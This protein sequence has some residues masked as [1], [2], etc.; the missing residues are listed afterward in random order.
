MS[1]MRTKSKVEGV[2]LLSNKETSRGVGRPKDRG[3]RGGPSYSGKC[4]VRL[5]KQEIS[6][7]DRLTEQNNV[8]RSEIMRKA[9][10]DFYK[11][12]SEE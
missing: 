11:F 9:L 4:D 2:R 6:M 1:F 8:T 10:R 5:D 7:L 12:N 3:V